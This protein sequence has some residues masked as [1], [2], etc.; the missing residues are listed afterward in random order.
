MKLDKTTI[1]AALILSL[2]FFVS[3]SLLSYTWYSTRSGNTLSVTG[4]AKRHITSDHVRWVS[5]F[6]R[7]TQEATLKTGYEQ[8]ARDLVAVKAFFNAKGVDENS[9]VI[10]PVSM[11]QVYKQNDSAPKE[12]TL[13]QTI[14]LNSGDVAKVTDL[15]KNTNDLINAGLVFSTTYLE[16]SYSKLADLR[17]SLL[18]DALKDAQA[19]ATVLA[20]TSG[21]KIGPLQ[22]AAS[23]VVQVLPAN[24]V[25]V[26]D[27]GTYDTASIEKEV[28]VTVKA[29]FS[30]K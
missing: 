18:G 6:T 11:Q 7:T 13:S 8:M 28:M 5:S 14:E 27:Y 3:T 9:L 10:S 19:R 21:S 17:V 15:A 2:T 23:G 29:S 25:D 20:Q 12:Y 26:S 30:I 22:S 4:S 1:G 24:S 16:Y